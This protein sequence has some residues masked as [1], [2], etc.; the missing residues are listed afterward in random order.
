M[1]FRAPERLADQG[2]RLYRASGAYFT[3]SASSHRR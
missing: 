3:P 1:V 2:A